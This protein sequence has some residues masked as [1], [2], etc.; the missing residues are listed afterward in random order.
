MLEFSRARLRASAALAAV[1]PRFDAA[2]VGRIRQLI[3]R[4]P[5]FGYRRLWALLRFR[6]GIRVNRK[7][8]YRLL[9]AG[10]LKISPR[11]LKPEDAR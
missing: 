10:W 8:V 6:Q 11:F 5:T 4:H 1:P 2:L 7:A 3:E 9:K